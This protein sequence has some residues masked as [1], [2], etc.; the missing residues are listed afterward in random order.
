MN[1]RHPLIFIGGRNSIPTTHFF[2][3]VFEA[4]NYLIAT[5]GLKV[6]QVKCFLFHNYFK[7][8]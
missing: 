5:L 8:L 7:L 4:L 6:M 3:E 2:Y 1:T